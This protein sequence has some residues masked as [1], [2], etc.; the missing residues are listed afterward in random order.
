MPRSAS[1]TRSLRPPSALLLVILL[2]CR[3]EV[4]I[5]SPDERRDPVPAAEAG[6]PAA[7]DTVFRP[8]P[9]DSAAASFAWILRRPPP[10]L[11]DERTFPES[12]TEA[13]GNFLRALAQTGT[14]SRGTIGVGALGY[15]RAF[16]Y[17]HPAVRGR[18]TASAWAQGLAGIVRSAVV[19]LEPVPGDSARVFAELLVLRDVE[20]QSLAGLYYGHFTAAPGD[21]GWQ[22]T[23]ARFASEDWQSPLGGHQPWRWDRALAARSYAA[24]DTAS[25][26]TLVQLKSGE[27]VPVDIPAPAA[28]L[29]FG[30][31]DIP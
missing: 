2:G 4:W 5:E 24:S 3:G 15:E 10:R 30:L 12:A 14:G 6:A 31:P 20:A 17:V 9:I 18:R 29:R 26:L 16:T 23:G 1:R 28:D 21:N 11:P 7:V 8:M 27:W 19:R 13:A 22:L 25:A